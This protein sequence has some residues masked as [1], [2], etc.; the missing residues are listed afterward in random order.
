MKHNLKITIMLLVMFILTQLIGL[1]VVNFYLNPGQTIPYG[2]DQSKNIEPVSFFIQLIFSFVI[3]IILVLLLMKIKS[4]ILIKIWFFIVVVFA[5][6]ITFNAISL[7]L[8]LNLGPANWIGVILG[9]IFAYFKI[10]KRNIFVHNFT[11]LL[12]YPGVATLFVVILNLPIAIILLLIV[13]V[14]DMWAVWKSKLM[15]KMAKYQINSLGIFG[16]FMIPY[17]DKKTKNK[18]RLLKLK[19]KNLIPKKVIKN[20]R[21]KIHMAILGGGD[22]VFSLI[23][24]GVFFKT[25][26]SIAGTLI[27]TLFTFLALLFLF[28]IGKKKKPYPAMPYLTTG[29]LIGMAVSRLLIH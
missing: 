15:V 8:G 10:Y 24:A 9:L 5:L 6:A 26:H 7:A 19:Y 16:G 25:Y 27:V 18:I 2:F 23:A 3:A 29:I 13:S 1:C 20:S 28:I 4:N 12:I 14:Y 17:A 11:E 22:L 21:I